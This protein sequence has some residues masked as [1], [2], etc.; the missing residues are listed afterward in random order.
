MLATESPQ[1]YAGRMTASN[2]YAT[3]YCNQGH[4]T[5]DGKPVGHECYVLPPRALELEMAG[6]YEG[7]QHEIQARKPLAVHRGVKG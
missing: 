4:R 1:C 6:D 3:T 5:S 7:A 2:I